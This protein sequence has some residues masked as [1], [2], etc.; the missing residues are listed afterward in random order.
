MTRHVLPLAI[1]LPCLA[2]GCG[3]AEQA[4]EAAGDDGGSTSG[5]TSAGGASASTASTSSGGSGPVSSASGG[6]VTSTS[7]A[8]SQSSASSGGSG[9]ATSSST[10]RAGNACAGQPVHCI[11]LCEGGSCQCDCSARDG[12]GT[13]GWI[14]SSLAWERFRLA[15]QA[16]AGVTLCHPDTFTWSDPEQSANSPSLNGSPRVS[17]LAYARID[18]VNAVKYLADQNAAKCNYEPLENYG[19]RFSSVDGWPALEQSYVEPASGCGACDPLPEPAFNVVANFYLAAGSLV[20][21]AQAVA[22]TE[23]GVSVSILF[24]IAASIRI[25]TGET[26]GDTSVDIGDLYQMHQDNCDG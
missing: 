5:A 7:T 6:G 3:S 24:D 21:I 17:F 10:T 20:L 13:P 22:A 26:A 11:E 18:H 25:D 9:G 16:G 4:D 19:I 8:T 12:C 15:D 1:W 14:E 2:L 23:S